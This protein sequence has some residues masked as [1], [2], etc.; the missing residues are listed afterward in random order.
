MRA[1]DFTTTHALPGFLDGGGEM[2]AL[3]R[4]R[5]W[6]GHPLGAPAGW[7]SLL[8]STLRLVLT[9]NHPMLIWWGDDLYQF[10]NDAY[11]RT[12]DDQ[13][14][15]AALGQRGA[16]CWAEAWHIIGHEIDYVMAGDG[17]TWHENALVPLTRH[18]RREDMYWTYGYSPIQDEERV[19]GV[20]AVCADVSEDM[21]TRQLLKQSYVTVVESMDEGLAVIRIILDGA[22]KPVDYRFLEVNPAFERQTGLVDV[23]GKTARHLVPDLEERW[24][25]VYGKVALTGESVRFLEGSEPMNRWF[26]VYATPV[27][28][29]DNLMVAVMFRDV[30]DR[31]RAEQALRIA[32][33]R[34]DEFLA[35]LAHEL[36]NPLAP[37][38]A[39]A[40]MLQM[41]GADAARVQH[42]SAVIGRQVRHITG[43]IDDL[44][45]VSRVTRGMIPLNSG[46][47][48]LR[49][50][51][52]DA[53]EQARPLVDSHGHRLTVSTPPVPAQVMGDAKR[54]VQ[55]LSN[56]LNNAVKYTPGG[57]DI[58]LRLDVGDTEIK[59]AV[60]DNGI[61]MTA[62]VLAHAFD[63][64][65]Q[66]ERETDRSQ[67]GLGIGLALVKSLVELHGGSVSA[68]SAGLGQGSRFVIA[69]PRLAEPAADSTAAADDT[70]PPPASARPPALRA[71]V[72]D[73]N[74]DA[75]EMLA[76]FLEIH[77]H[78]VL[79]EDDPA[80]VVERALAFA[81]HVCLLDIGLPGMDGY[82]LARRIRAAPGLAGVLLIAV[83]GYGDEQ[84]RQQAAAAGFDHHFVKPIDP[85]RLV[86]LLETVAATQ[87]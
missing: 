61:G 26:E 7:P 45:D 44:L 58:M 70:A 9:S 74:E 10:Y 54:L 60:I 25:Q 32:D 78:Q 69:L 4:D 86:Q 31:T 12:M 20:L 35:M 2:G 14:H 29:R 76:M 82:E 3:M 1:D 51:V 37:I 39:A 77:G 67:G 27:G 28:P 79:T 49:R 42:A 30:T 85:A 80:R 48:D 18:G 6:T 63:L 50:V 15:P 22:G 57:G 24:F 13:R 55:V 81:P 34:K 21:R 5:D 36:R 46:P 19:R 73:D 65:V 84:A 41:P 11:R 43:L 62:D 66:A 83:T 16:E 68:H 53:I 23:V 17:A 38:S 75:A 59:L 56:L 71:M 33:R 40:E 52:A 87:D 72:V 8:K 47:I 64:F